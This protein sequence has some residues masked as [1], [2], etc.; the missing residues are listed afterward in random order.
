MLYVCGGFLLIILLLVFKKSGHFFKALFTSII[1]GVG[2]LCAVGAVGCFIPISVGM[3]LYSLVFSCLFSVPGVILL[4]V[5]K[6][7]MF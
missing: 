2:A 1:G 4:L 3:N 7:F 6:T 5:G